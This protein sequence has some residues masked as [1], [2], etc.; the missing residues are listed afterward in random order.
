[1]KT[2]SLALIGLGT[3]GLLV[4]IVENFLGKHLLHIAAA[5]YIHT[6]SALFL[7]AVALMCHSRF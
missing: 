6:A 4:A 2:L 1:M 3:L 5:N 7:L